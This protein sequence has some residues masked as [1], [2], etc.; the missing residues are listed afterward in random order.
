MPKND[1]H[2]LSPKQS[3]L[4]VARLMEAV[5]NAKYHGDVTLK[6]RGGDLVH[7]ESAQSALPRDIL[8]ERFLCVLLRSRD[9]GESGPD[10]NASSRSP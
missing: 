7:V 2:K 9:D 3:R 1:P 6:F 10:Q 8:E 5:Q 4:A